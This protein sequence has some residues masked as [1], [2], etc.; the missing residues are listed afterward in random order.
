MIQDDLAELIY[1]A[2]KKAQRKG[3]LPKTEIPEVLI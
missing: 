1:A 2:T 3:S